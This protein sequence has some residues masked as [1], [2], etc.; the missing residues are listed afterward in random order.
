MSDLDEQLA[1]RD[2]FLRQRSAQLTPAQR[3]E[4][5]SKLQ[6]RTWEL[7][8]SSQEGYAHFLRRNF[9]ARATRVGDRDAS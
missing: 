6:R 4:E 2:R 3:L 5:M 9:K 7:L 1:R 8:R